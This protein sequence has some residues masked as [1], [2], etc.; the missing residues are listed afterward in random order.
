MEN[1]GELALETGLNSG[2]N[3]AQSSTSSANSDPL[4]GLLGEGVGYVRIFRTEVGGGREEYIGKMA[5]DEFELDLVQQLHGGGSYLFRAVDAKGHYL[6]QTR[7]RVA[8]SATA[9][10]GQSAGISPEVALLFKQLT[11]QQQMLAS[12]VARLSEQPREPVP[13][14][15][16]QL[17][18]QLERL[19]RIQRLF[20]SHPQPAAPALDLAGLAQSF[21][22]VRQLA[23]LLGLGAD[24]APPEKPSA[25]GQVLDVARELVPTIAQALVANASAARQ[26]PVQQ[27]PRAPMRT[28]PA[29]LAA[30]PA[31][32]AAPSP[33]TATAATPATAP[34]V[35]LAN[36]S[37]APAGFFSPA[38]ARMLGQY[39]PLL[40]AQAQ[41]DSDP[42]LYADMI[43]DQVVIPDDT[44]FKLAAPAALAEFQAIAPDVTAVLPWFQE[45]Q[46]A[47]REGLQEDDGSAVDE[48][49]ASAPAIAAAT[50]PAT[51][52][53]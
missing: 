33:P 3:H 48:M 23:G 12:A 10:E 25:M 36:P 32:I 31:Q 22:Q 27:A 13:D 37:A 16:A 28:I 42:T 41:M 46:I 49:P 51:P 53:V 1:S 7:L 40:I 24:M 14:A 47:I 43:L 50:P 5:A 26:R 39:L 19:G 15:D 20:N 34:A 8:A 17:D 11:E 21:G 2:K 30:A 44:K 29:A 9:R 35:P 18:V 45:L 4:Q 38:E 6:R 52:A